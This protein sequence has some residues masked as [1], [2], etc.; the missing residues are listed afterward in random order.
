[1]LGAS[2]FSLVLERVLGNMM[3]VS[4]SV[5]IK[6][7][8]VGLALAVASGVGLVAGIYPA[9]RAA[10]QDPIMALRNE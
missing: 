6:P 3:S 8:A 4:F 10:S 1:V 7:W 5:P 2:A 9:G